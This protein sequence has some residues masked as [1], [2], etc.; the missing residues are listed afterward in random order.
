MS[1]H[2]TCKTC[3]ADIIWIVDQN[4]T[5]ILLNKKRVRVYALADP[6]AGVKDRYLTRGGE[7]YLAYVSHFET[8]PQAKQHSRG[9][10][11]T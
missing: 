2:G 9:G 6:D 1:E 10:R 7:P 3:G 4:R 11:R 5:R 8:C